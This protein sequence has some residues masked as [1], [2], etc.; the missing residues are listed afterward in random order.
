MLSNLELASETQ[1]NIFYKYAGKEG[2]KC[3]LN[4][5]E[6]KEL[7]QKEYPNFLNAPKDT[8][9]VE[10]IMQDLDTNGDGEVDFQEFMVFVASLSIAY[11]DIGHRRN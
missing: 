5:K 10:M 4:K 6:L 3:K 2:D 7:L 11:N 1:A 9:A 8:D